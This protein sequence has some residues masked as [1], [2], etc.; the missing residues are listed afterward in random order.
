MVIIKDKFQGYELRFM[1][2]SIVIPFY[3]E[4]GNVIPVLSGISAILD[5]KQVDYEIIAVDNNSI[6]L[7]GDLIKELSSEHPR[8]R[9]LVVKRQGY[10]NAVKGGLAVARGKWIGWSDG[11]SQIKPSDVYR[12]IE[13]TMDQ[14][15][16]FCKAER[17]VRLDGMKRVVLMHLY[18]L[19]T[20]LLLRKRIFDVNGKPK[21]IRRSLYAKI[22]TRIQRVVYRCGIPVSCITVRREHHR[23]PDIVFPT[24]ERK[25]FNEHEIYILIG[26]RNFPLR[27]SRGKGSHSVGASF[28]RS[29]IMKT[30]RAIMPFPS[31]LLHIL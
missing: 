31:F 30:R 16:I 9:S 5:R 10:G 22:K 13:Q 15:A 1:D 12:V 6:D 20:S 27:V 17:R 21:F 2:I 18:Y 8:I 28:G 24:T 26:P 29:P 7:T 19:F 4:E 25:K 3:N 23:C 11:D 14:N